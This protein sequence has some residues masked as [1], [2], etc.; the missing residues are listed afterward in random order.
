MTQPDDDRWLEV[1]AGRAQ[2][3]D[4]QM[5][6][7]AQL[8]DYL[9]RQAQDEQELDEA[10]LRR[11]RNM[12]RAKADFARPRADA[13]AAT[14]LRGLLDRLFPPGRSGGRY[15]L[16]AGIALAMVAA[17][18]LLRQHDDD[19]SQIKRAPAPPAPAAQ[20]P[21][22]RG[23]GAVELR[24]QDPERLARDLESALIASGVV[25]QV[26]GGTD[27]WTLTATVRPADQDAVRRVLQAYGFDTPRDGALHIVVRRP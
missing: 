15:A 12:V 9:L 7:A 14:V 6:S 1:L 11:M 19:A 2:A 18:L 10:S 17:P 16:V 24:A 25:P 26:Q 5:R 22:A 13:A 23:S 8:R 4:P 3:D 21:A 27:A 20:A